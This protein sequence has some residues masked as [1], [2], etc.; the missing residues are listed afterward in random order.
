MRRLAGLLVAE[1]AAEPLYDLGR[2][3]A[4]SEYLLDALRLQLGDVL[5][6]HDASAEDEDVA[7][8]LLPKQ[9]HHPRKER[10]VRPR[11]AGE[12]DGVRVLLDRGL[13]DLLGRLLQ[14]RVDDLEPRVAERARDDL[15][16]TVVPVQ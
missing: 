6:R 1:F 10:H 13:R 7:R 2:R 16:A 15:G 4:G 14:A 8:A 11:V 5:A 12:P 9:L 3:G